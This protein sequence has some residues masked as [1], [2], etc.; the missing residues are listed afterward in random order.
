V[1]GEAFAAAEAAMQASLGRTT[2]DTLV[3]DLLAV[4]G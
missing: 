4:T 3:G 2:L 1:L